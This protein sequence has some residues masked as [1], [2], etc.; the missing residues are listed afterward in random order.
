MASL[1]AIV[2]V[3]LQLRRAG[4][5]RATVA[6]TLRAWDVADLVDDA[7]LIASELFAS[8]VRDAPGPESVELELTRQGDTVRLALA[9]GSTIRPIVG[10]LSSE[11]T[12][13]RGLQIVEALAARWGADDNHGG[14]R[15]WV[16]LT[17][18]H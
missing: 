4:D 9:D 18:P 17:A 8:A 5:I 3:P 16:E 1:R 14:K 2:D 7:V 13:G 12:S 10:E 11:A 6:G 15:V